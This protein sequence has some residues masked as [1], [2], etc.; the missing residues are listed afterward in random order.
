MNT[1]KIDNDIIINTCSNFDNEQKKILLNTDINFI[2]FHFCLLGKVTLNYNDGSYNFQ[3]NENNSI[4]LFNPSINLP[5]DGELDKN[6]K[7]SWTFF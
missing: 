2:Q 5:I 6:S 1:L 7:I 4:I 3:L